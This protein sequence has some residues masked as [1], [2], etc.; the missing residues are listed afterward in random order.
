M[1]P[2]EYR[3]EQ[4]HFTNAPHA[5]S[6]EA[7]LV[8]QLNAWGREGWRVSNVEME[9]HPTYGPRARTVLLERERSADGAREVAYNETARRPIP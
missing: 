8:E 4:V 7:Q 1:N 9:T 6:Y 3:V 2:Y 5:G